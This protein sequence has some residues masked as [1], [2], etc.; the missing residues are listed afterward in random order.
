M[1]EPSKEATAIAEILRHPSRWGEL[2]AEIEAYAAR[3]VA[4][5][6]E[7]IAGRVRQMEVLRLTADGDPLVDVNNILQVLA[8]DIA[9]NWADY[10]DGSET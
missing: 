10:D 4:Q 6:R 2:A 9:G 8:Y 1:L 3:K 5:E 7:R